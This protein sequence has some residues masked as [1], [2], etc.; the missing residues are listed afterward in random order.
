VNPKEEWVI[1]PDAFPAI[2]SYQQADGIY[3]KAQQNKKA[4]FFRKCNS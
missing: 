2:I 1:V 4:D 3:Q